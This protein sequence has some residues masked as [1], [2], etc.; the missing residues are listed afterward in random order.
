MSL[1][2]R[3]LLG[4]ACALVLVLATYA[5]SRTGDERGA[6]VVVGGGGTPEAAVQRALELAGGERARVLILPHASS[7]EGRGTGSVEMY[8]EAG[9][10]DVVLLEDLEG[11]DAR[12]ALERATLIWMPGGSQNR[13]MAA[14]REAGLVELV[15]EL[16]AAGTVVGGTSAGAAVQSRLMITG[17][18]RLDAVEAEATELAE[19][20]AL[21]TGVI[22]D[23]HALARRR[24]QRLLAAVL[25]HP[26]EV[27][28]AIDEG[29]AAVVRG[30]SLEVVGRGQVVV[31]DARRA[32]VLEAEA[33]AL[34]GATGLVVHVLRAGM[35]L[36]L[37]ASEATG[38]R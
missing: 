1:P 8:E 6:L 10:R 2:P 24:L 16:H 3:Q 31:L 21:W 15:R 27:G 25:D 23:Q 13:L 29:T 22:V 36:D 4:V 20:L 30:D 37:D 19:G 26:A 11:A 14:L 35:S 38:A 33:G 7:R 12:A 32:E 17:E 9:A 18:A 5:A 28:V 34:H